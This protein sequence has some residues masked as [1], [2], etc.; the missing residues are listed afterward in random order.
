MFQLNERMNERMNDA[1]RRNKTPLRAACRALVA[2][3]LAGAATW[4]CAAPNKV[5]LLV[6]VGNYPHISK[7]EGPAHDVKA[8]R[9]VLIDRWGYAAKD[10]RSLV[11][12]A[13]TRQAVAAELAQLWDRTRPGDEVLVYFSGHGTSPYQLTQAASQVPEGSGGYMVYDTKADGTNLMVGRTDLLPVLQKLGQ[14]GRQVWFVADTCFSE[15]LARN[16]GRKLNNRMVP[17]VERGAEKRVLIDA[18]EVFKSQ[19]PTERAWPYQNVVILAASAAGEIAIDIG[20]DAAKSYLPTVDGLPHG[21]FTDALLRVLMGKLPADANRD[22][23]VSLNEVYETVSHFMSSRSYGHWPRRSPAL[24]EDTQNLGQRPLLT[25]PG[26]VAASAQRVEVPPL[27]VFVEPG[28]LAASPNLGALLRN[29]QGLQLVKQADAATRVSVVKTGQTL[30]LMTASSSLLAR[31]AVNQP[32]TVVNGLHQMA[33]ADKIESLAMQGRRGV[34]P[35]DF[36]PSELGVSREVG[37]KLSFTVKPERDAHLLMVNINALGDV[38]VI[39]PYQPSE[40]RP[41][42]GGSATMLTEFPVQDPP[43]TD[44][45]LWF[46]FERKP[47]EL[48]RQVNR[49]YLKPGDSRLSEL[50]RMIAAASGNYT[51]AKTEFRT[52]PAGYFKKK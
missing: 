47:A 18:R 37:D 22:G 6:G 2:L 27:R 31:T 9:Q 43:G 3:A 48:E 20:A 26:V 4:A 13:A 42:A 5:A 16:W 49:L 44:I 12:E 10:V 33:W 21:A 23:A 30:E 50:E 38:S 7:L 14:G 32:E 25:G 15:N 41:I 19:T 39:Y 51:F 24:R 28:A 45:Q 34:L 29:V 8:L 36:L 11:D 17:I 1:M 35:V 46:A 40:L 52:Y